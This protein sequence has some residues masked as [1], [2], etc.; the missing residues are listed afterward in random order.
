MESILI[1]CY[2]KY[3]IIGLK[4]TNQSLTNSKVMVPMCVSSELV[5]TL[6]R[7]HCKILEYEGFARANKR[8][9]SNN[10]RV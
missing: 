9:Y 1:F 10:H 8:H 7:G 4:K 3:I 2:A 5:I 6:V